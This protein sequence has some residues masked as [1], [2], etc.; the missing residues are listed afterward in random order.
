MDYKTPASPEILERTRTAL[1]NHNFDSIVMQTEKEALDK[2]RELIPN[3]ASIMNGSSRT[4][5]EIGFVELLK[6]GGHGWNNLHDAVL[7]E[8]DKT[9][10]DLLRRQSVASDYYLGSA[11][12]ITESGEMVFASNTGSQLPHL[13]YTSTNIILVVGTHKIVPT[14]DN[15]FKRIDEYIFPLEN[16]RIKQLYGMGTL[17]SKTL[18]YR[19]ESPKSGRK[20]LVIFVNKVLGF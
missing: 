10:Q 1:K 13:A 15:A 7:A 4:L 18:V 11:H 12:A 9:K 6:Q 3:G 2:I 19:Q 5:E 20:I 17:H 14:L 16:E 8:K